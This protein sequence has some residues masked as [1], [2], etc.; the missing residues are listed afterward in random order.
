MC[1]YLCIHVRRTLCGGG[2]EYVYKIDNLGTA[3]LDIIELNENGVQ[4]R[5]YSSQ[6]LNFIRDTKIVFTVV[7]RNTTIISMKY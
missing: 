6:V 4:E 1:I 3:V 7:L 2:G 5:R